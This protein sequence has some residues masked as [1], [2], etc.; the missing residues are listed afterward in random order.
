MLE[1]RIVEEIGTVLENEPKEDFQIITTQKGKFIK[2]FRSVYSQ[3][4]AILDIAPFVPKGKVWCTDD[5]FLIPFVEEDNR[6]PSSK[7]LLEI[8]FQISGPPH[9]KKTLIHG[10]FYRDNVVCSEGQLK[11][12][13]LE[14]TRYGNPYTDIGRMILREATNMPQAI[15]MLGFLGVDLNNTSEIKQGFAEFCLSQHRA[16]IERARPYSEVPIIR[17]KRILESNDDVEEIINALKNDVDIAGEQSSRQNFAFLGNSYFEFRNFPS[18]E[19]TVQKYLGLI[20]SEAPLFLGMG[21]SLFPFAI[22]HKKS[23]QDCIVCTNTLEYLRN[24]LLEPSI[25]E[26]YRV[27]SK[28][29]IISYPDITGR[30]FPDITKLIEGRFE[31]LDFES[32]GSKKQGVYLLSKKE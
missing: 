28:N 25:E 24:E 1:Q 15:D 2:H 7:E 12:I 31:V 5:Y 14:Q 26:L 30:D 22:P 9:Q 23:S 21:Y 4:K 16:R 17:R 10:D 11:V 6:I 29:L 8:L 20:K 13:D 27:A 32:V 19:K 3:E 18:M